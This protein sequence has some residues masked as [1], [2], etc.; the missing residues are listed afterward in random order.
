MKNHQSNSKTK[1][2]I[3][4]D[5]WDT[6]VLQEALDIELKR[7]S[8]CIDATKSDLQ[9]RRNWLVRWAIRSV[10][11]ALI[12]RGAIPTPMGVELTIEDDRVTRLRVN[13]TD[14]PTGLAEIDEEGA[15]SPR[16]IV[17]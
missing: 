9:R 6:A 1:F 17:E 14:G 13:F 5:G 12:Q 16:W 15:P 10:C 2:S 8:N 11:A 4:L 3:T 7:F